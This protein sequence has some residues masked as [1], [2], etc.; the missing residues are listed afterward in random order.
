ML[1]V[2]YYV[3]RYHVQTYV[4]EEERLACLIVGKLVHGLKLICTVGSVNEVHTF[5]IL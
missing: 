1:L 4:S 2:L 5:E 3:D